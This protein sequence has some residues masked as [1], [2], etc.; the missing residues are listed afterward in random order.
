MRDPTE[1]LHSYG[2]KYCGLWKRELSVSVSVGVFVPVHLMKE[3]TKKAVLWV[4]KAWCTYSAIVIN[5]RASYT[6][7]TPGRLY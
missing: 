4:D 3:V 5:V 7:V 6:D 1:L 2:K